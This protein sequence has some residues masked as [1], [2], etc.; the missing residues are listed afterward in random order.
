MEGFDFFV[1]L[2]GTTVTVNPFSITP[3][4]GREINEKITEARIKAFI[5][6]KVAPNPGEKREDWL[7]RYNEAIKEENAQKKDEEA[8]EFIRRAVS[9]ETFSENMGFLYDCLKAILE[10]FG[11]D[12]TLNQDAFDNS[13]TIQMNNFV[14]KICSKGKIPI[15]FS[16]INFNP[17]F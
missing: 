11:K 14:A 6:D 4:H 10:V 15:E 1:N 13:S 9:T 2:G 5:Q 16:E 3:K 8:S 17:D 7:K 12:G